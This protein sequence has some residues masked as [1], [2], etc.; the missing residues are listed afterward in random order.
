MLYERV[1]RRKKYFCKKV[2]TSAAREAAL[3][4][5]PGFV[6]CE[7]SGLRLHFMGNSIQR[8][9]EFRIVDRPKAVPVKMPE[10]M[11]PLNVCPEADGPDEIAP[12]ET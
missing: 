5:L 7:T 11:R 8:A 4:A 12:S 1:E 3:C 2:C 6:L 10:H 9:M